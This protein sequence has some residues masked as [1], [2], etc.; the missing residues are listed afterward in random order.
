MV[1]SLQ[2]IDFLLASSIQD[3]SLVSDIDCKEDDRVGEDVGHD[4][5]EVVF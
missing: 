3:G 2:A 4:D 5:E 1:L